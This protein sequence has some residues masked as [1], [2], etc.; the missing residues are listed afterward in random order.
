M[1]A[2]PAAYRIAVLHYLPAGETEDAVV[3]QLSHSL[4]ELGHEPV[5]VPVDESV[6]DVLSRIEKARCD[7]VFNVCETFAEDYRLEVN[8]AALL[9]LARHRFTGSGTTGLLLAQDKILTKQLLDYHQIQTPRFATFDG[10][11]FETRGTLSFP[12]IVKPAKSDASIGLTLVRDWEGLTKRV[13]DIRK[14]LDDDALA[15]EYIE[16]REMYVGVIG[17]TARPEI[18]PI[19]E[20]DFGAAWEADKPQIATREV[21]FGPETKDSPRLVI[22]KDISDE[23]RSRMERAALLTYRALKLR[24][25]ARIDF[26]VSAANEPY[27]LEVNPNPYLE[28]TSEM[29]L[30]AKERGVSYTQLI[31]RI[32]DSAAARYKMN[33]RPAA[34]G[35]APHEPERKPAEAAARPT[36]EPQD[37][38]AGASEEPTDE[39]P[40]ADQ[41][42]HS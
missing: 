4:R 6:R 2:S 10:I 21:K 27:I 3:G 41:S 31:G 7:L 32:V 14:E 15:E 18:L 17:E 40:A 22:A 30:G 11:T 33:K 9:E 34:E 19:V 12:L 20:L 35:K 16:G 13:R 1:S 23:L 28:A 39:P 42:A 29:A 37:A 38:K 25:Y 26:R 36:K 5:T 8:I 24:D